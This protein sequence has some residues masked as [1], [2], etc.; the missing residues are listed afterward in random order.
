M[1]ERTRTIRIV[2]T[3]EFSSN[4]TGPVCPF[5]QGPILTSQG[6]FIG[7]LNGAQFLIHANCLVK[8]KS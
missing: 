8:V 3:V 7:I 6:S 2:R 5:C 4:V 1:D